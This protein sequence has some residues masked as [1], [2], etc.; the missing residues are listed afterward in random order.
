MFEIKFN[1]EF[2]RWEVYSDHSVVRA[3][4]RQPVFVSAQLREA[5]GY[6][7]NCGG[8]IECNTQLLHCC[9]SWGTKSSA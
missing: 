8:V 1:T 2:H 4:E 6:V 5:Q 3:G 9:S 7:I